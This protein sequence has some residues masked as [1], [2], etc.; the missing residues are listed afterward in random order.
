MMEFRE[1]QTTLPIDKAPMNS[2]ELPSGLYPSGLYRCL[3]MPNRGQLSRGKTGM[4][5]AHRLGTPLP[6]VKGQTYKE[7][8]NPVQHLASSDEQSCCPEYFASTHAMRETK[9]PLL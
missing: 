4:I 8:S 1:D 2:Q 6:M 3:S 7:L 5:D 9:F